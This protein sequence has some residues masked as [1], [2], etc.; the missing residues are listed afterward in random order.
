MSR[1]KLLVALATLALASAVLADGAD[2][3]VP[4]GFSNRPTF[5]ADGLANVVF[6]GGTVD[7]LELAAAIAGASG[8]WAQDSAGAFQVLVVRGPAFL[9]DAFK[10]RL[11]GSLGPT[12]VTLTAGP[13]ARTLRALADRTGFLIGSVIRFVGDRTNESSNLTLA[14][15]F[16]YVTVFPGTPNLHT[17]RGT[18]SPTVFARR[19]AEVAFAKTH[20]L[21]VMVTPLIWDKLGGLA[22]PAGGNKDPDTAAW[23]KFNQPDCGGWS[24]AELDQ[25][26]KEWIQTYVSRFKGSVA[27]YVVVNEPFK[28]TRE[29]GGTAPLQEQYLRPGLYTPSDLKDSCWKKI[30]GEGYI[31]KAF[32]YAHEADPDA[33]LIMNDSFNSIRGSDR[34]M[35]DKF[36]E[37]A[38]KLK[39]QGVPIHAVGTQMHLDASTN[40]AG[41]PGLPPTYLQDFRDLLQKARE[42]GVDV[43]VTEMDVYLPP[44]RLLNPAQE[45]KDIYKGVLSTC[46]QF[47]NC[48]AVTVFGVSDRFDSEVRDAHPEAAPLLFDANYQPKPAYHGVTEALKRE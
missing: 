19:D 43:Q 24:A 46:L 40:R 48:T 29:P 26:M 22:E 30:L 1:R 16:N 9:K 18:F 12:A 15:E 25:I 37:L 33:V 11:P 21:K 34:I 4:P 3:Q 7:Q 2:A 36:M 27:A 38:R 20:G 10:A 6:M 35:Q 39:A 5:T 13:S 45:L 23:M 31:A 32:T 17:A 47:A 28:R 14:R 42:I 41:L 44:G 8:V